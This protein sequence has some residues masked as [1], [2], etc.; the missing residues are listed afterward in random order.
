M[1]IQ[2]RIIILFSLLPFLSCSQPKKQ[3][4]PDDYLYR[5]TDTSTRYEQFG[6]KDK[7]GDIA[8][9]FGKYTWAYTDTIKT[10]GFV[11]MKGGGWA[12]N[13]NDEKLFKVF[14]SPNN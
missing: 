11:L 1:K 4:G 2:I 6:Y 9:P 13:K 5:V 10:I 12:I 14:P 3:Y 8:I 7:D